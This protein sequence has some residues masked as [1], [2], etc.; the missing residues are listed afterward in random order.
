MLTDFNDFWH[1]ASWKNLTLVDCTY[2]KY[3]VFLEESGWLWKQP[4]VLCGKINGSNATGSIQSDHPVH[5]RTLP[6]V[7][8]SAL[9][10]ELRWQPK[11]L[12]ARMNS[13]AE[14][15]FFDIPQV[16]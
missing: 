9:L 5:G 13:P 16:Q 7:L 4:V 2:R 6:V 1:T 12:D 14:K 10:T 8:F 11:Q 3:I 15:W